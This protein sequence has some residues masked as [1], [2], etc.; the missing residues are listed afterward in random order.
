MSLKFIDW[1]TYIL[2]VKN[3]G[4]CIGDNYNENG[5]TAGKNGYLN[6]ILKDTLHLILGSF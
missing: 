2:P 4:T 5:K 3:C 6:S 1:V